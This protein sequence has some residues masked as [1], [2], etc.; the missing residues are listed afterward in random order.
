MG[1][2]IIY[3]GITQENEIE[4][5][6]SLNKEYYLLI[7]IVIMRKFSAIILFCKYN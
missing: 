1:P 4:E 3:V 2:L 7:K 5:S 6:I